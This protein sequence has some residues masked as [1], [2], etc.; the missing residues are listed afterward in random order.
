ME[1]QEKARE[2]RL[3][4][5]SYAEI[6]R[7]L[8]VII[9][10]STLAYWLRDI[11]LPENYWR[12]VRENN[13]RHLARVR[14][15]AVRALHCQ[16]EERRRLIWKRNGFYRHRLTTGVLKV[17]LAFLYIGEGAKWKSHRGLMLGSSSPEITGLY[18]ALL[19]ACYGIPVDKLR[20]RVSHRADQNI[21]ALNRYWSRVTG[22]P[23]R[24]FTRSIPDPRTLG[25]PTKDTSYR[26]VC[27]VTCGST[28]IQLELQAICDIML[29]A[30]RAR[31]LEAK[32]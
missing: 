12:R 26:G 25:K 13:L 28:D 19:H 2:L 16:Q 15:L 11:E 20:C 32:R 22:I 27:V 23:L 17:A 1:V 4:G 21:S 5:K 14:K 3:R 31:S 29:A 6:L 7:Q 9:P 18:V 10:Q 24:N 30:L 8:P